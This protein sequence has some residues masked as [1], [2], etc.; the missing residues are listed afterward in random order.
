[1]MSLSDKIAFLFPGDEGKRISV[2]ETPSGNLSVSIDVHGLKCWQAERS[3]RNLINL[4]RCPFTLTIIHGY[5]HGT[6][7]LDMVRNDLASSH[8]KSRYADNYNPGVTYLAIA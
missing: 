4:A 2:T 6:A 3:I 7:I 1:M 8:I 5:N